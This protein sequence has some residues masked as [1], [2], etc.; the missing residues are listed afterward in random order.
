[1][2]R[3]FE[4]CV[5]TPTSH[6][7][8]MKILLASTKH[9]SILPPMK[10]PRG[11]F[12]SLFV[13]IAVAFANRTTA[14]ETRPNIVFILA[15]DLG[16]HD[17]GFN[18]R[19]EWKTAS[20][21]KLASQ[22][23]VFKRW[24]VGAVVCAPSRAVLMTGKYTIHNGVTAN[25]A[26][27]PADQTTIAQELKKQGYRTALF[28]KWHAGRA[29]KGKQSHPLD[30]GFDEFIGYHDAIHAWEHF[31]KD[32]WFGRER[33]P[34][35]NVFYSATFMA[36]R[37]IEFLQKQKDQPFFLYLPFIEPHLH[38]E[39]P[40]QDVAKFKGKF[41]E[42]DP[43]KPLNATY[44]AMIYRLD[45]EIGRVMKALDE[46]GLA[47]STLVVFTS[48]HG[49]TFEVRNQGT[50]AFH[51]SNYPFRGQKRT[52]WEGGVRVPAIVRWPGK[53][54]SGKTSSEI[55]HNIDVFPTLLAAAGGTPASNLKL[56]GQNM[57]SVWAGKEKAPERTLFWEWRSEGNTQLAAM[58]GDLK[59]VTTG[60]NKPEMFNVD[61]DPAE[62]RSIVAQYEQLSKSMESDLK[63]WLATETEAA[64]EKPGGRQT[65]E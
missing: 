54:P 51:D 21:D 55:I 44:A 28:G 25:N 13:F 41:P 40:A 45:L 18:G 48:D 26:D 19:K 1:M 63:A 60:N 27:L 24:Y 53:V 10:F 5:Y 11:L 36:D 58:R 9:F 31:P 20:L 47:K 7:T 56:D 50:A 17:V 3:F 46:L 12:V 22:G 43:N 14:A 42:A 32:L 30:E 49:A 2:F 57:L 59:L 16:W 37:A 34:V 6:T 23:T 52:L 33:K 15:D 65:A 35:T 29:R 8:S 61:N 64:K 39:A 62:R 4:F 38:I